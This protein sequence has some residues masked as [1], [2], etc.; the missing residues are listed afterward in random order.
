MP[1]LQIFLS[2]KFSQFTV[3]RRGRFMIELSSA[4]LLPFLTIACVPDRLLRSVHG[5]GPAALPECANTTT[6]ARDNASHC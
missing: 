4:Q 3:H 6:G 2:A 1:K 5:R